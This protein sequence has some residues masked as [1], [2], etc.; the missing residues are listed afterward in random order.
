MFRFC[1]LVAPFFILSAN[2]VAAQDAPAAAS[3][4]SAA[5]QPSA[6]A[7]PPVIPAAN[8]T[9][10]SPFS[11][12]VLSPDGRTIATRARSDGKRYVALINADTQQLT[13]RFGVGE[14]S[15][16]TRIRWAGNDRLL[17]SIF[18]SARY[19]NQDYSASRVIY[20]NLRD[21]SMETLGDY[22][23][24]D[25]DNIIFVADDG[26]YLLMSVQRTKYQYPSVVRYDLGSDVE[27]SIV[28]RQIPGVW[29]WY[30]D[31]TGTVRLATGIK[32][33][34][35]RVHY[36][37]NPGEKLELVEK[38]KDENVEEE[39]WGV[40]HIK[41]GTDE[42]YV[43]RE[44][45][46]GRVGFYTY[47][48]K[49]R[50]PVDLL[51]EHP[52][53]DL[54]SVLM[55]EDEP[56]AAYYTDDRDQAHWFDAGYKQ[57]YS[58]LSAALPEEEMWISS[59]SKDNSRMIVWA[60]GPADP[61]AFYIFTP[62]E[63]RLALLTEISPSIDE[64]HLAKPK[65][66]SYTARDGTE[67]RSILTLPKGVEPKNLPLIIM[68]HGGPYGVRDRLDYNPEVQLLAN[69][70]YA[71]LQPNFR[72]SGG[73][74]T[75]FVE[76]GNGQ[77]GRGMQDDLDDAMDWAVGEGIAAADRVCIVG[78]SYGGYAALWGVIRNPERY[79]CAASFAGV[80][81]W[82][83][84]LSYDKRF[85]M[86]W[87]SREWEEQV[88]GEEDFD[89]DEVSPYRLGKTLSRPVL[90]AQGKKDL[91]VPYSQFS[92]FTSATKRAPV[93]PVELVFDDEGHSFDEPENEQK[94]LE[95]LTAFLAEHNPAG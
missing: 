88:V 82:D 62:A 4:A 3:D 10:R 59:R 43:L 51:Y 25:G 26:S 28:E 70:G 77:I 34:V 67:I 32:N 24:D 64:R 91:R 93:Q 69:R 72:G 40:S 63:N 1:A 65:A 45:E 58:A 13:A 66:I 55:H 38:I 83:M 7:K 50:E 78:A 86:R 92:K 47:N 61:G 42:A 21:G 81:D 18:G 23:A 60:G 14:G 36:R 44:G 57:T 73:Y 74:G 53:Y 75:D 35:L 15:E 87:F 46:S 90:L 80:T 79:R 8:F 89:L 16:I 56:V 37:S 19:L 31:K 52:V 85:F 11:N 49:T 68:P 22:G 54:D 84:I 33:R 12:P 5:A 2:P 94:W 30:T 39:Y 9:K 48:L 76:L 17:I 71:V 95:E 41:A 27:A 20:I 29:N 6:T